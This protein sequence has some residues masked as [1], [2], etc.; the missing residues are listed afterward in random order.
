[1]TTLL[2]A[3]LGF[4]LLDS[5]DVL[6]VG[7]TAAIVY[8][9]R[10]A[11]RSPVPGGVGFLLGVFMVTTAFGLL[12]VLGVSF[13]ADHFEV[14]FTPTMRY[15]AELLVGVVLIVIALLPASERKPPE[16]TARLRRNPL[17]LLGVGVAIGMAQAPTAVPYLAGLGMIVAHQP[18]PGWWPLIV[19]V[20]CLVALIPPAVVL[21]MATRSTTAARRRYLAVIR[22]VTR[23]GP[24]AVR[25][26]FLVAGTALLADAA[27]NYQHLL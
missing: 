9:A 2:L 22:F 21:V 12:T 14:S 8:D 3:L 24:R 25:V 10:L 4:S 16:W 5:L 13:L 19:V 27:M 20:Y 7:A 1:M 23:Y 15:W 6:L 17:L 18:L 26:V 11:R